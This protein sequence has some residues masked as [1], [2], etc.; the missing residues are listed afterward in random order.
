MCGCN[1]GCGLSSLQHL[2]SR[3]QKAGSF[4]DSVMYSSL[5]SSPNLLNNI[6]NNGSER[7]AVLGIPCLTEG[8]FSGLPSC[9]KMSSV[10]KEHRIRGLQTGFSPLD[11]TNLQFPL[12]NLLARAW[13]RVRD[14]GRDPGAKYYM[15]QATF[16]PVLDLSV[17]YLQIRGHPE[18]PYRPSL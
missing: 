17:S 18:G 2:V 11:A 13:K 6:L 16:L 10:G 7:T 9:M 8:Y 1:I 12:T 5:P 3:E 4:L 15:A 14:G